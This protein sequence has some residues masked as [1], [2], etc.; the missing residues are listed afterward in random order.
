[1]LR[2]A[3][4]RGAELT[5]SSAGRS[6]KQ[7]V[8]VSPGDSRHHPVRAS[9]PG[10]DWQAACAPAPSRPTPRGPAS[11]RGA[12]AIYT[13]A[14]RGWARGDCPATAAG[15]FVPVASTVAQHL[16]DSRPVARAHARPAGR[17]G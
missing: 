11:R 15:L 9:S 4:S 10:G 13:A 16:P 7:G 17:D 5:G 1:M 8:G 6:Q 12:L 3:K 14:R 2:G